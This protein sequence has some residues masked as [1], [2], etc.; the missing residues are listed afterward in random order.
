M[1]YPKYECN[2]C[3]FQLPKNV[4]KHLTCN[5]CFCFWSFLLCKSCKLQRNL[6]LLV[7]AAVGR[8]RNTSDRK[9][10]ACYLQ[11]DISIYYG[12]EHKKTK[13][14]KETR[15]VERH[16]SSHEI[17]EDEMWTTTLWEWCS[18]IYIKVKSTSEQK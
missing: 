9:K 5:P 6:K 13:L 17:R 3:I 10:N 11:R 14:T 18:F 7:C 16:N 1:A 8:W 15:L 12:D 4:T 2:I